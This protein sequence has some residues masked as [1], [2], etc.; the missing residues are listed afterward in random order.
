MSESNENEKGCVYFFK[1]LGL[2]PVK[3][4]YSSNPSPIKR[5]NSFRTYAPFGAEMVGFIQTNSA[6]ELES[7]LHSRFASSRLEGE[8]FDLDTETIE[9]VISHYSTIAQN[10]ERNRFMVAYAKS[11]QDQESEKEY[12]DKFDKFKRVYVKNPKTNKTRLADSI[13]VS[14]TTIYDWIKIV[15][16]QS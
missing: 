10:E 6:K 5:F 4:G 9:D 13:G 12:L 8:W 15:K 1:H 2:K 11:L 16:K 3:I 14:R 7:R